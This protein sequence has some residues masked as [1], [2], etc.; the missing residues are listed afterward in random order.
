[1]S[2][3][4]RAGG[5]SSRMGAGKIT[6]V[7]LLISV[8]AIKLRLRLLKDCT[9]FSDPVAVKQRENL[10]K[11]GPI[12]KDGLKYKS[13]VNAM[14]HEAALYNVRRNLDGSSLGHRGKH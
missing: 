10:T 2:I 11:L 14:K 5:K 8:T 7:D 6:K 3:T 4:G 13:L 1:M 9:D 12:K